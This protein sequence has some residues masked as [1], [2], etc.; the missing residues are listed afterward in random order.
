[1]LT[2]ELAEQGGPGGRLD[3]LGSQIEALLEAEKATDL[4][5]TGIRD[6]LADACSIL[7]ALSGLSGPADPSSAELI[8]TNQLV[9][10][11]LD[12]LTREIQTVRRRLP[13]R[14]D[15][16]ARGP[17]VPVGE[18]EDLTSPGRRIGEWGLPG[19]T[20]EAQGP[21]PIPRRRPGS[22]V[23]LGPGVSGRTARDPSG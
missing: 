7:E 8:E 17:A 21:P 23:K 3:P 18:D 6:R 2:Q 16:A 13:V 1:M 22:S 20:G 12:E 4:K 10:E 11:R 15:L 9:V 14:G 19:R 5:L